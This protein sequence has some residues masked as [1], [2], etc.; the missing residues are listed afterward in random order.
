MSGKKTA[1]TNATK[2][3]PAGKKGA[4]PPAKGWWTTASLVTQSALVVLPP[5]EMCDELQ[6]IRKR[7]DK[8]FD[9]WPAHIN[10]LWPFFQ[11]G[12]ANQTKQRLL[13]SPSFLALRPF[14]VRLTEFFFTQGSKYVQVRA[15]S[16]EDAL[17]NLQRIIQT[18]FPGSGRAE[19]FDGHLSVGQVLPFSIAFYVVIL[20]YPLHCSAHKTICL[21]LWPT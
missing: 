9:K 18:I 16:D 10:L 20:S 3:I 1:N 11:P 2:A 8:S 19:P 15:E 4:A 13:E 6:E 17:L 7:F 12:F 21:G 14:R 5:A